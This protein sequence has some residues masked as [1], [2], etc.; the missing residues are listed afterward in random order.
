MCGLQQESI[1][2]QLLTKANLA[3]KKTIKMVK[4]AESAEISARSLW[5]TTALVDQVNLLLTQEPYRV[6]KSSVIAVGK[7]FGSGLQI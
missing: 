7:P 3:Y 4:A 1:Q 2:G 5:T 6:R